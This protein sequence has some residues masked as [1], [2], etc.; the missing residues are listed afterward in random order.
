MTKPSDNPTNAPQGA[1]QGPPRPYVGESKV[2]ARQGVLSVLPRSKRFPTSQGRGNDGDPTPDRPG[3]R[4]YAPPVYR[5]HDDG[6]RWSKRHGDTPNAAYAC[7]CGRTRTATGPRAVSA[8][9]ADYDGH[10][11]ACPGT[12]APLSLLEGRTA[13]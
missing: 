2:A 9:V 7:T 11:D 6:A 1:A 13:A 3:I 5:S 4:I 8:L 12:P 10:K